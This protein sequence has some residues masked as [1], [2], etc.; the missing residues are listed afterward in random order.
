M[1]IS[2]RSTGLNTLSRRE[3]SHKRAN[4]THIDPISEGIPTEPCIGLVSSYLLTRLFQRMRQN[5]WHSVIPSERQND[6]ISSG[7]RQR[8]EHILP[9]LLQCGLLEYMAK[10][11]QIFVQNLRDESKLHFVVTLLYKLEI[12]K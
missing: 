3:P 9:L 11:W 5:I 2:R 7:T 12:I 6:D 8:W 4:Y 1:K 10:K